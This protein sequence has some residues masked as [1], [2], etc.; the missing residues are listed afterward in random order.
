LAPFESA[1]LYRRLI[2]ESSGGLI[3]SKLEYFSKKNQM[4]LIKAKKIISAWCRD[5]GLMAFI[6]E[7]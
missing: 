6:L 1:F 4:K 7:H 5:L 3:I 2:D